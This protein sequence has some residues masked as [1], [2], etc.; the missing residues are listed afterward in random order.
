MLVYVMIDMN[1]PYS[2]LPGNVTHSNDE[3]I[4]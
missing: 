3:G 4:E 1:T 2:H